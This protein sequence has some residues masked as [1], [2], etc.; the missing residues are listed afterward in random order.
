MRQIGVGVAAVLVHAAGARADAPIV[1]TVAIGA[2]AGYLA[3]PGSLDPAP[4]PGVGG[5][6]DVGYR[7][8]RHVAIGAHVEMS[9]FL[10]GGYGTFRMPA[11]VSFVPITLGV[12][13]Q[14][15]FD[16]VWFVPSVGIADTQLD[17]ELN[18]SHRTAA[19]A[20]AIG[21]DILA[22]PGRRLGAFLA[23]S[24]SRYYDAPSDHQ[25]FVAVLAGVAYRSW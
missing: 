23:L 4:S 3:L 17:D 20:V 11:S 6:I 10:I 16:R 24:A 21:A 18:D 9:R 2:G 13:A 15:A 19:A 14:I 7:V 8:A 12:S 5:M 1:A 25:T 22:R